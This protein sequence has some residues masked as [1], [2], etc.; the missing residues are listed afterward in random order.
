MPYPPSI[1]EIEKQF[2][3]FEIVRLIGIGGQK[4]VFEIR[5]GHQRLVLKVFSP[6][7][8]ID[9]VQREIQA[10]M[11]ISSPY[12][13]RIAEFQQRISLSGGVTYILEEYIEGK[14]LREILLAGG[15]FSVDSALHFLDKV[16]LGLME[17]TERNIV[18]LDIKPENIMIKPDDTPVIIDFGIARLLDEPSLT[19][20]SA[21][22][23]PC[24]IPYAPPEVLDYHKY[25]IDG[26]SDL[27]SLGISTYEALTG[28]HPFWHSGEAPD[29]NI[30][31]MLYDD[32][33][34][35][36]TI[37][38]AIP[39]SVSK[40][41]LRLMQKDRFRRFADASTARERLHV[42]AKDLGSTL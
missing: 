18:H 12:V 15:K 3:E 35:L 26:R 6:K 19:P 40:F 23:R 30:H 9:R 42:V 32:P 39:L 7:A 1:E 33:I 28:I 29:I 10:M 5:Q 13:A 38:P 36:T 25:Q 37:D 31:R 22:M 8:A 17:C 41:V 14:S 20:T 16:L 27:F 24:T 34:P 4:T 2:S 11:L 21:F